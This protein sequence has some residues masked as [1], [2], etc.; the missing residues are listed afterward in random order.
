[1]TTYD[2]LCDNLNPLKS[3]EMTSMTSKTAPTFLPPHV[4][5]MLEKVVIGCHGCHLSI[6]SK[7]LDSDNLL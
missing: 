7:G 5:R 3:K 1:M 4:Y 6:Y 2:I